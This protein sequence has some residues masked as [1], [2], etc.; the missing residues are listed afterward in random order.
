MVQGSTDTSEVGGVDSLVR[1]LRAMIDEALLI[2]N[3]EVA[4]RHIFSGTETRNRAYARTGQSIAY[5]GNN[6]T[7]EEEIS[8]GLRV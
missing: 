3:R 1:D 6:G 4:G 7:I 2:A 8:A 5:Q